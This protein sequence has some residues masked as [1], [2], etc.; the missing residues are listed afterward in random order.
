MQQQENSLLMEG[1]S[2]RHYNVSVD[3]IKVKHFQNYF[4]FQEVVVNSYY[5]HQRRVWP[6][7]TGREGGGE[8]VSF[9]AGAVTSTFWVAFCS[10]S[11]PPAF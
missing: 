3:T 6:Y 5:E 10:L 1:H 2:Y 7:H 11:Q 8:H 9:R 4:V